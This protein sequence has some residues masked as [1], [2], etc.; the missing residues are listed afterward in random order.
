MMQWRLWRKSKSVTFQRALG[1]ARWLD[2][3]AA[4][5]RQAEHKPWFGVGIGNRCQTVMWADQMVEKA[6]G[7]LNGLPIEPIGSLRT[8]N[9]QREFINTSL[10]VGWRSG[11]ALPCVSPQNPQWDAQDSFWCLSVF[12]WLNVSTCWVLLKAPV[13]LNEGPPKGTTSGSYFE[14]SSEICELRYSSHLSDLI[15]D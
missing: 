8:R 5:E 15:L 4:C 7:K 14:N 13:W 3:I 12:V 9:S 10:L 6:T 11:P 2:G 1:K